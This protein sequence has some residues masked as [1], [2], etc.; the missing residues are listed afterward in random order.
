[1][2]GSEGLVAMQGFL[3][4]L[5]GEETVSLPKL[6]R[7]RQINRL[8]AKALMLHQFKHLFENDKPQ[9]WKYCIL[10]RRAIVMLAL[11]LSADLIESCCH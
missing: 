2:P 3:P 9:G 4:D 7:P 1:M 11:G 6:P 5:T 10:V 8:A